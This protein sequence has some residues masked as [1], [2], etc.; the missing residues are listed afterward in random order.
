MGGERGRKEGGRF[1]LSNW[2]G[3]EEVEWEVGSGMRALD[4]IGLVW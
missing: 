2:R 1:G 3:G 4:G